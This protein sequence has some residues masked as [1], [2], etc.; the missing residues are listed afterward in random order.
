M[1]MQSLCVDHKLFSKIDNPEIKFNVYG[2]DDSIR[3]SYKKTHS[4]GTIITI[5]Y[6]G[7]STRGVPRH[8]RYLRIRHTEAAT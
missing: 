2:M 4:I 6:N 8:P 3:K 1:H 7:F 5:T